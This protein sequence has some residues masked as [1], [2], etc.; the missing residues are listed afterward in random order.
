MRPDVHPA[1]ERIYRLLPDYVRSA[2]EATEYTALR[3]VS[4]LA[5]SNER[6][7]DMLTLADP[8]TSASGTCELMN[9]HRIPRAWLGWL[10]AL[11]GVDIS[12]WPVEIA[13]D[14]VADA[15]AEH[16]SGSRTAIA[17]A[18]A[19]TLSN[20][21]P[22]PRVWANL[23]GSDPYD[24]TVVTNTAQTPDPVAALSAAMTEKPFGMHLQLQVVEATVL[25]E[26]EASFATLADIEAAFAT[27]SAVE[28][29]IP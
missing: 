3:L 24:I 6:S 20:Q 16:R 18:V 22:P 21:V 12:T 26:V 1:A 7:T 19:R 28:E 8:G 15:G 2:D 25:A 27:L 14:V 4:A 9:A 13:R 5:V 23:S 17:T 11:F 29:W 10:G